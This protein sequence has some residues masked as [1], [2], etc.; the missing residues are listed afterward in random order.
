MN[1]WARVGMICLLACA[2]SS[3]ESLQQAWQLALD[4]DSELA[5][6]A[7]DA[8]A[9][10]ASEQGARASRWPSL[11]ANAGFTR[12][13][14][15]PEFQFAVSGMA[16]QVPI[17]PGEDYASG[18]LTARLPLYT[19]GRTT[20]A[21]GAAHQA[22]LAAAAAELAVRSS[23]RLAVAISYVDV[24]RA[25]RLL[26][27]AVSAVESL[28]AH[29]VDVGHM[30]DRELVARSDLLAA[31]VALANAEQQ[32]VRAD[33]E[34]A[35]AYAAY[36]RRLGQ[37]LDRTPELEAT[38]P[39]EPA[40]AELSITTLVENALE[41]R[42]EVDALSARTNALSLQSV[43]ERAALLPQ[44]TLSAGYTYFE[45]E[46]L[47]R[48]DFSSIGVGVTWNIFDGGVARHRSSALKIA[49]RA[50][51][52]R[53]DDLRTQ[54]ELEV[55]RAWLSVREAR[56]RAAAA[57]EAVSQADENL[58][59]TRELYGAG[60]GTNTQVL[61]ASS[62]QVA[63]KN[64]RDNAELDASLSLLTLAYAVGK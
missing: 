60:L 25:S 40:L 48:E 26:A 41:R 42:S 3:A 56:A 17:I 18:N 15:A 31:Q 58:R 28:N 9:A 45:N 34:V 23:S 33:N 6:A 11:V 49:S 16:L 47:D 63:A 5:A 37:S 10:R 51:Q 1:R 62:L 46:I 24:L 12:F 19:G 8:A 43:A 20:A 30:V 54:I 64:N 61:D 22:S 59:M 52:R 39:V 44:L 57:S 36:N 13:D 50:A 4:H 27:T 7:E 2:E 14:A 38:L 53:L 29:A 55:R 35:L 32:R 21:I